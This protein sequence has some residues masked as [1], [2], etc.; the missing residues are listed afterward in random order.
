MSVPTSLRATSDSLV[1]D[2]AALSALEGEKRSL[3]MDD[4]RLVE[5]AEQVELI[6]ARV[7]AGTE[8]QTVLAKELADMPAG[9]STIADVQRAPSAILEEWR[10]AERR[11]AEAPDGSAEA[12][13]LRI[14]AD[15]LRAEYGEAYRRTEGTTRPPA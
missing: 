12:T 14:L 15:R 4:P 1:R 5:I 11:L 6:A 8:R 10:D 9:G 3:P 7:L 13:E 2:L